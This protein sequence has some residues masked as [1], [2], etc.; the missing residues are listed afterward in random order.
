MQR[1]MVPS[2][3]NHVRQ[4]RRPR[5]GSPLL[6]PPAFNPPGG[7]NAWQ[8]T[9]GHQFD[10]TEPNPNVFQQLGRN[11]FLSMRHAADF[12][13]PGYASMRGMLPR[14]VN[15]DAAASKPWRGRRNRQSLVA[16]P[17]RQINAGSQVLC[18][19]DG[20][21]PDFDSHPARV[22]G[23]LPHLVEEC[24]VEDKPWLGDHMQPGAARAHGV[25]ATDEHS[26]RATEHTD[27]VGGAVSSA[28]GDGD[29]GGGGGVVGAAV[30]LGLT[31]RLRK[32]STTRRP[33]NFLDRG[34]KREPWLGNHSRLESSAAA[35]RAIMKPRIDTRVSLETS[36]VF[37]TI[38][39]GRSIFD[40]YEFIRDIYTSS[41]RGKL[42]LMTRIRDDTEVIIKVRYKTGD[43]SSEQDWRRIMERVS[44]LDGSSDNVLDIMEILEASGAFY[45]VMPHCS[46]GDLHDFLLTETEMPVEECKRIIREILYAIGD[47]HADKLV[48]RDIKLEN[49]VLHNDSESGPKPANVVKLIDFDTVAEYRPGSARR[50]HVVGT[51]GYIA[52]EAFLG[53][54]SP[55]SDL[56]AVGVIL[57]VFMT[58]EMPFTH[59]PI[60][61]NF[62]VGSSCVDRARR[63]MQDELATIDWCSYPWSEF[64]GACHLC[65]T[66]IAWRVEDRPPTVEAALQHKWLRTH[67]PP[68]LT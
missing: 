29:G 46:A 65:Q 10:G 64:P 50:Q 18:G 67:A 19:L 11:T 1:F 23:M 20:T 13:N 34:G 63:A 22:C 9:P 41:D 26:R 12:L 55:Q 43:E 54:I 28:G 61:E 52:P 31:A 49:F 59:M 39:L 4:H 51:P 33:T 62:T 6:R 21:E 58:A 24:G 53:E 15:E 38:R 27:D 17:H 8:E 60:M 48:H 56:W 5:S 42:M 25:L 37:K 40:D 7:G 47:L 45:V 35:P 32:S 68:L 16:R 14:F 3:T 44:A 57:Y 2:Q 66:L 36:S 30:V